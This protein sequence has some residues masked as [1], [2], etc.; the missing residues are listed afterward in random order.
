MIYLSKF[1]FLLEKFIILVYWKCPL[2]WAIVL[3][4]TFLE[5]IQVQFPHPS[6]WTSYIYNCFYWLYIT[7][8]ILDSGRLPFFNFYEWM[9]SFIFISYLVLNMLYALWPNFVYIVH[10]ISVVYVWPVHLKGHFISS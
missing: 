7:Q 9:S 6:L 8:G 10:I 2:F 1:I 3:G 5:I 4:F